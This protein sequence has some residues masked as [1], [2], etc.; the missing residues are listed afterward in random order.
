MPAG[1]PL[2]PLPL[3]LHSFSPLS[4]SSPE[5]SA[6]AL[7]STSKVQHQ[8]I[9]IVAKGN[10]REKLGES[11]EQ[12]HQMETSSPLSFVSLIF[13]FLCSCCSCFVLHVLCVLKTG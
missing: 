4:F 9:I 7:F 10:K 5:S 2:L 8:Q 6:L 12:D 13:E 1:A 3:S 11:V